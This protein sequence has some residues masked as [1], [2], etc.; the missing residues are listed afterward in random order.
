MGAPYI[1]IY[2]YIYIYDISRLRVNC[3]TMHG[4]MNVKSLLCVA[5]E[6][7]FI[8][9]RVQ[10][11][12]NGLFIE[13]IWTV[14]L[15]ATVVEIEKCQ[16]NKPVSCHCFS[17]QDLLVDTFSVRF[18]CY[19]YASYKYQAQYCL[20]FYSAIGAQFCNTECRVKKLMQWRWCRHKHSFSRLCTENIALWKHEQIWHY[21][22][23]YTYL[24]V[25]VY[26]YIYI[27]I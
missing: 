5:H 13:V 7:E 2:I 16:S 3:I 25:C 22:Y 26:I 27:Y 9:K 11:L 8:Y 21:I 23:L 24:C 17:K 19:S 20:P 6:Q 14:Q 12:S 15:Q 18:P 1:Y 10:K 4:F